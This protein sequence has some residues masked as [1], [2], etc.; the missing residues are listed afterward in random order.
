MT[1]FR[2]WLSGFLAANVVHMLGW[3]N[4]LAWQHDT[5]NMFLILALAF[6]FAVLSFAL[7]EF[8]DNP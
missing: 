7:W 3:S 1:R 4:F 8:W 5:K 6:P 2:H